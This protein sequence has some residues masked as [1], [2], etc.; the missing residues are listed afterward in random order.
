MFPI[1]SGIDCS[2]DESLT[3]TGSGGF[4]VDFSTPY[5]YVVE[6]N[7]TLGGNSSLQIYDFSDPFNT[8]VLVG[9]AATGINTRPRNP[10]FYNLPGFG[11][12]LLVP[13]ATSLKLAIWDVSD[14]TSPTLLGETSAYATSPHSVNVIG[15]YACVGFGS[16]AGLTASKV[17]IS[18]PT[19]PTE[20]ANYTATSGM[21]GK[22]VQVTTDHFFVFG[23]RGSG[24]KACCAALK[25][26]D[27]SQ[28]S[29]ADSSISGVGTNAGIGSALNQAGTIAYEIGGNGDTGL[30]VWDISNPVSV[31]FVSTN[32]IG[33]GGTG[34]QCMA[35]REPVNRLYVGSPSNIVIVDVSST[36]SA[37]GAI[38]TSTLICNDMCLTNDGCIG[39]VW[40]QGDGGVIHLTG[41][42]PLS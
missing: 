2:Y 36:P 7:L 19:N 41:S 40:A 34:G 30:R 20:V 35:L 11:P 14:V 28:A 3:A 10:K 15:A 37:V 18:D 32:S 16:L 31:S 22:S 6:D 29:R 23:Q 38:S 1:C 9:S 8:P 27:F 5:L 17:D 4:Y 24:G 25:L 42:P 21:I 33:I 26:S 13:Y 39:L 12:V